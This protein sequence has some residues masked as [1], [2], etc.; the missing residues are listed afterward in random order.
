MMDKGNINR[1][2]R[3]CM[4]IADRADSEDALDRATVQKMCGC[5]TR[6]VSSTLR[7]GIAEILLLMDGYEATKLNFEIANGIKKDAHETLE[8]LFGINNPSELLYE[9]EMENLTE[10]CEPAKEYIESCLRKHDEEE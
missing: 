2:V 1:M 9:D 4:S 7:R 3:L 8:S 6:V 5:G 10:L